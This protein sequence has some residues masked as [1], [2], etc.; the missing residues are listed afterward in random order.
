MARGTVADGMTLAQVAAPFRSD[1]GPRHRYW[2]VYDLLVA[3]RSVVNLLEIGVFA[4]ESLRVWQAAF[5]AATVHGVDTMAAHVPGAVVRQADAYTLDTYDGWPAFDLIVD[6]GSHEL[7][8]MRWV[9][10]H[11]PSMLAPGGTLV[12][13][14]I[15]RYE[16][17]A[18]LARCVPSHL[19]D[20]VF[21]VD[22]RMVPGVSSD[23]V[24]LVVQA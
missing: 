15:R 1:K 20:R 13:E 17:V 5:P 8:D 4:G 24:L 16:W 12:I 14:D 9:A 11:C 21:A 18:E 19:A 7:A 6:D 22:R 23:S 10:T 2:E 3:G